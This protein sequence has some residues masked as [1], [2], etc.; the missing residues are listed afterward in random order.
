MAK[1]GLGFEITEL[2][3]GLPGDNRPSSLDKNEKKRCFSEIASADDENSSSTGD[4]KNQN[5]STQIVGWPP[6][7]S[8]RKKSNAAQ[9]ETSKLYVKVSMDG[10]PFLRKIDLKTQKGYSDLSAAFEELFRCYGIGGMWKDSDSSEYIPIYEDKDG[11]WMLVGDVPWEMF[12]ESCKRLRIMKRSDAK[13]FK[14]NVTGYKHHR[15][16][17]EGNRTYVS[18]ESRAETASKNNSKR[19]FSKTVDMNLASSSKDQSETNPAFA[20]KLP[21]LKAQMVGWPP[22]RSFRKSVLKSCKYVKLLSAL[23]KIFTSFT[24][25]NYVNERKLMDPVNGECSSRHADGY[26]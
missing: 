5:N 16:E 8:Y 23:E 12:T 11:D 14:K 24:I 21:P 6:V 13:A 1:E 25:H 10:A 7:C 2:R 4:R 19:A 17:L 9:V 3:L 15:S 22:V 26:V 18:G 20:G